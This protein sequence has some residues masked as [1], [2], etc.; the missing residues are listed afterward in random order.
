MNLNK[1]KVPMIVF[2][3]LSAPFVI[4]FIA[5]AAG[6]NLTVNAIP[7]SVFTLALIFFFVFF[8]VKRSKFKKEHAEE[9]RSAKEARM[10]AANAVKEAQQAEKNYLKQFKATKSAG[11]VAID[12]VHKLVTV[13]GFVKRTY[14]YSD[15]AGYTVM[16]N[17]QS[18]TK[19]HTVGRAIVGGAVGGVVGAAVGAA[20][21]LETKTSTLLGVDIAF[22]GG[23]NQMIYILQTTAPVSNQAY[24]NAERRLDKITKLLD[25]VLAEQQVQ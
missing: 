23:G 5:T 1:Y 4:A 8:A 21:G 11:E 12:E 9:F 19:N 3:L 10:Q 25:I 20:S 13:Q 16:R 14:H 6:G 22:S 15:I 24:I 17:T 18:G 7:G 2:G